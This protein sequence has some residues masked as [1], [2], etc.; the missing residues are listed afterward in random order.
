MASTRAITSEYFAI[1]VYI[2][3]S[4]CQ[5]TCGADGKIIVWNLSADEPKEEKVIEGVIPEVS[6]SEY[7]LA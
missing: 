2:V 7:V 4:S 5:T 3:Y 1:H 6:D